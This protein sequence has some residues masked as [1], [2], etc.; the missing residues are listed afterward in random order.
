[1]FAAILT[2]PAETRPLPED[3]T[4]TLIRSPMVKMRPV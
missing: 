2:D 4:A 3:L 1:M